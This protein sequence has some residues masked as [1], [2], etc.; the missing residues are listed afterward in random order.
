MQLQQYHTQ[1]LFLERSFRG[2]EQ[3]LGE[4]PLSKA[5]EGRSGIPGTG[6]T[7]EG[8]TNTIQLQ[9]QQQSQSTTTQPQSQPTTQNSSSKVVE[10]ESSASEEENIVLQTMTDWSSSDEEGTDKQKQNIIQIIATMSTTATLEISI[11]ILLKLI[12]I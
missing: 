11:T 3:K 10:K 4:T 9:S 6:Y 5:I 8:G 1:K 7:H 12:C 2:L